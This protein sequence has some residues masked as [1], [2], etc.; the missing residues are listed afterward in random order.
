MET[1]NPGSQLETWIRNPS[2]SKTAATAA[3]AAATYDTPTHSHAVVANHP[4]ESHFSHLLRP[5]IQ[6]GGLDNTPLLGTWSIYLI[7]S[8]FVF[9]DLFPQNLI[10]APPSCRYP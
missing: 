9:L 6:I 2:V 8:L 5:W 10:S 4:A 3:A 7:Q 1:T